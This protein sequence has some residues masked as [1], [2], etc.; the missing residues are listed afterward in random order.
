MKTTLLGMIILSVTLGCGQKPT[1][2]SDRKSSEKKPVIRTDAG[3]IT[4][5]LPKLGSLQSVW[6]QSVEVTTH[7]FPSPP[8]H[9]VYRVWGLARVESA[10]A[11]QLSR[12]YEWQKM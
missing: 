5:R 4:R 10:T 12:S 7:S 9:S 1:G 8:G 11:E 2:S 6:W 3:P